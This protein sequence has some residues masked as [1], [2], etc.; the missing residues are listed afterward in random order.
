MTTDIDNLAAGPETDALVAKACSIPG[1]I[2][3]TE[4]PHAGSFVSKLGGFYRDDATLYPWAPSHDWNHAMFAAEKINLWR[5]GGENFLDHDGHRYTVARFHFAPKN[6]EQIAVDVNGPLCICKA[7]IL[8][9]RRR[10]QLSALSRDRISQP[11]PKLPIHGKLYILSAQDCVTYFNYEG[12][13]DE[14][15]PGVALGKILLRVRP[16]L[17]GCK[18]S[19]IAYNIH[20]KRWSILVLHESLPLLTAE[21]PDTEELLTKEFK[22][23]LKDGSSSF[24]PPD[25]VCQMFARKIDGIVATFQDQVLEVLLPDNPICPNAPPPDETIAVHEQSWHDRPPLL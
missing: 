14:V 11:P 5:L 3:D 15:M 22:E 8:L 25:E 21:Q 7:I 4:W 12:I 20:Q 19:N 18:I 23:S 1:R 13:A 9:A 24:L 17:H 2:K 16:E 6:C 10:T